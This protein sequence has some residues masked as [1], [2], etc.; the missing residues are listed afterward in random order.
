MKISI[1]IE[2][3]TTHNFTTLNVKILS[4]LFF[5]VPEVIDDRSTRHKY[6]LGD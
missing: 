4:I 1:N 6:K 3:T 2:Q 5:T